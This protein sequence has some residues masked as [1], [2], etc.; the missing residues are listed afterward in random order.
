[1]IITREIS[2][3]DEF[4]FWGQGQENYLELEYTSEQ[5]QHFFSELEILYPDGIDETHL[6]DL[7]WH[8]IDWVKEVMGISEEEED[9]DDDYYEDEE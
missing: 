3:F 8:E 4:E 9:E 1:M 2:S 6:N 7:F 5:E